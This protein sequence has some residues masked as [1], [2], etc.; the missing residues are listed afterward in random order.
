MLQKQNDRSIGQLVYKCQT[1]H[2][3]KNYKLFNLYLKT[4]KV[5]NKIFFNNKNIRKL[6]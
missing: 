4:T 5:D 6:C 1:I 3:F 2:N